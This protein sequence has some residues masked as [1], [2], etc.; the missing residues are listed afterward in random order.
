MP[1]FFDELPQCIVEWN[2]VADSP[3]LFDADFQGQTVLLRLNDF[4]E[5]PLYTLIIDGVERDFHDFPPQWTLPG[6]R[7]SLP[8]SG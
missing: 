2:A 7:G 1:R 3:N 8:P 6:H 4:P 5:E